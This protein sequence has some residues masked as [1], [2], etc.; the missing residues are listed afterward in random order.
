MAGQQSDIYVMNVDGTGV[1]QLTMTPN[2]EESTPRCS[3]DGKRIAFTATYGQRIGTW[4][5]FADG[6]GLNDLTRT[7][8]PYADERL[9][10]WAR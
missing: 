4:V 5:M 6:T 9:G 2:E 3:P 8:T 1:T 10:A 7:H